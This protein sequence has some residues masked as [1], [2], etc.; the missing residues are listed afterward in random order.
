MS[1]RTSGAPDLF[2]HIPTAIHVYSVDAAASSGGPRFVAANPAA[3]R[4][5]GE[6][7]EGAPLEEAFPPLRSLGLPDLCER[8]A[9]SGE[10][11]AFGVIRISLGQRPADGG[12]ALHVRAF[13]LD[14]GRVG[15]AFEEWHFGGSVVA[16][17]CF[18]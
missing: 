14:G 16:K 18:A 8:V 10:A 17:V 12:A 7:T 1:D 15:V 6:G 5:L 2:E 3:L 11:A 13:P 4:A 9:R